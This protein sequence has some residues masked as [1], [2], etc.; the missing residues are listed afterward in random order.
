MHL[1]QADT[2]VNA[3]SLD[4]DAQQVSRP[5]LS[6]STVRPLLTVMCHPQPWGHV[7][8]AVITAVVVLAAVLANKLSAAEGE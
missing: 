7:N 4:V 3:T 2:L 8:V 6:D 5:I 1:L